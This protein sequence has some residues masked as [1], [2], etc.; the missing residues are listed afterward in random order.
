MSSQF[1]DR[2]VAFPNRPLY[3]IE[4]DTNRR[5]LAFSHD[6]HYC[7]EHIFVKKNLTK[8]YSNNYYYLKII[9]PEIVGKKLHESFLKVQKTPP[10][11]TIREKSEV[12]HFNDLN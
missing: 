7:H 5:L 11:I 6:Y 8:N 9:E 1:D 10:P 4:T 12:I 2:E 3:I